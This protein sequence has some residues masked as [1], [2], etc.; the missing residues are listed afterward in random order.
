MLIQACLVM[1]SITTKLQPH[2]TAFYTCMRASS[3]TNRLGKHE[4]E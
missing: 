4:S 2:Q 1:R 3:I